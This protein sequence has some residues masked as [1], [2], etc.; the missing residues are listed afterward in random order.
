[1][2]LLF[3]AFSRLIIPEAPVK[4]V[5][6][7]KVDIVATPQYEHLLSE[8]R[9]WVEER[10]EEVGVTQ[11]GVWLLRV[12][13]RPH[14]VRRN[15]FYLFLLWCEKNFFLNILVF[16]HLFGL[17][18]YFYIFFSKP[19]LFIVCFG[20]LASSVHHRR[21]FRRSNLKHQQQHLSSQSKRKKP[22][23]PWHWSLCNV[24]TATTA[25]HDDKVTWQKYDVVVVVSG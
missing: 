16:V 4:V 23:R 11:N 14:N 25:S 17:F 24:T 12:N 13:R 20:V 22:N 3:R 9:V 2:Y 21:R 6:V 7:T 10:N 19:R 15:K 18:L 1:M 8:G 5:A